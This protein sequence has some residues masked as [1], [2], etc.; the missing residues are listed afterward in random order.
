MAFITNDNGTIC[1]CRRHACEGMTVDPNTYLRTTYWCDAEHPAVRALAAELTRNAHTTREAAAALFAWVESLAL[2]VAPASRRAS[3]T[4]ELRRGTR[5][6]HANALVA[7]ARSI[8][9][10]AA[11]YV[12][13][14][15]TPGR[16]VATR[17]YAALL[18]EGAW[19]RCLCDDC[20]ESAVDPNVAL[21]LDIDAQLSNRRA[22]PATGGHL[23]AV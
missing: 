4:I 3:E 17:V 19:L 13:H 20:A 6:N 8:G 12:R 21:R 5:A 16:G 2:D 1:S 18:I 7:L 11:F 10:P 9:I 14:I 22:I 15:A 23:R